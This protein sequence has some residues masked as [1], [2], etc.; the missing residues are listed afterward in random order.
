MAESISEDD[1]SISDDLASLDGARL[2]I[3]LVFRRIMWPNI[4]FIRFVCLGDL[5]TNE[6][7][8]DEF[9]HKE[10]KEESVLGRRITSLRH[11]IRLRRIIRL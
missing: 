9:S 1:S 5:L 6:S 10:V 7:V 8:E 11:V 2:G 3:N 4:V